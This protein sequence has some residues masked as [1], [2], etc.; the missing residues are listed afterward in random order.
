MQ[1][2]FQEN[3]RGGGGGGGGGYTTDLSPKCL[4]R[5]SEDNTSRQRVHETFQERGEGN[6]TDEKVWD[7]LGK[8]KIS[9]L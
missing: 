8:R 5:L 3:G 2:T 7:S 4:Q 1:E 9:V 6:M